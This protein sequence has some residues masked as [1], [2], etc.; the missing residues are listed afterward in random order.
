MIPY[1]SATAC[2]FFI[3]VFC[4]LYY[5]PGRWAEDVNNPYGF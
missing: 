4:F 1:S 5:G 2:K 3:L